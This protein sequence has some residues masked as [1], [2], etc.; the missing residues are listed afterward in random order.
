MLRSHAFCRAAQPPRLFVVSRGGAGCEVLPCASAAERIARCGADP[1]VPLREPG[2]AQSRRA[3]TFRHRAE[4]PEPGA[5][6]LG[7]LTRAERRGD[8]L[9][10]LPIAPPAA[11]FSSVRAGGAVGAGAA[12]QVFAPSAA[13][14]RAAARAAGRGRLAAAAPPPPVRAAWCRTLAYVPRTHYRV[15]AVVA[16]TMSCW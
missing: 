7:F 15:T 9:P 8:G 14:L 5:E 16:S 10:A 3:G 13:A 12:V 4:L 2:H 11:A 6:L 1:G